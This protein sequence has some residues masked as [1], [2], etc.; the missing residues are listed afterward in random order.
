MI[1][2]KWYTYLISLFYHTCFSVFCIYKI[3]TRNLNCAAWTNNIIYHSW[4]SLPFLVLAKKIT[5]LVQAEP[6]IRYMAASS[7]LG[8]IWVGYTGNWGC[9]NLNK[10]PWHKSRQHFFIMMNILRNIFFVTTQ[11]DNGIDIG[12]GIG[13]LV[14]TIK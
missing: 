1:D 2:E 5:K 4:Q 10:S 9:V 3:K 14:K 8:P 6:W 11:S 7:I 12:I 13:N